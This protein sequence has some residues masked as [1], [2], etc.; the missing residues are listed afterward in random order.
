VPAVEFRNVDV[1]FGKDPTAALAMLDAGEDRAAILAQT[2]QVIGVA[3]ASIAIEE[4]EICV[5]MGLSGSGKSTLLRCVNGLNTVSRGQVLVRDGDTSID[6]A[7]CDADTLRRLRSTR[8]AMVF[9]QFALLPWRTVAE[10]VGLGLELRGTPKA[11]R[12][13]IVG[14]KLK[15]VS[16]DQWADKFAHELSG[17]MQ[18]RVG[19]ARAFATDA[20]ILLMD[21]PFSALDPLIR[22]HLQDELLELQRSLKKTIIF[23]SHDLDEALKIG[24]HIAIMDGGRIVQYGEPEQ[25]VLN[26]A[27]E[28]VAEFVAHM[29]PLNVLRGGSLMTPVAELRRD[30]DAVL[31]DRAGRLRLTLDGEDR[32]VAVTVNGQAGTV[33][34]YVP[35]AGGDLQARLAD[36]RIT[37]IAAPTDMSMRAAIE[38]RQA[39]GHPVVLVE[40]GKLVGV[41]GDEEI[42]RGILRQTDIA[43]APVLHAKAPAA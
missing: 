27:N 20:D 38:L 22:D 42:Y 9:Q 2:N 33:L 34:N 17:G 21:E 15:L 14:E 24:T 40:A 43:A 35:A 5:L 28:Y 41:C 37:V 25:I 11:E 8:I 36:G 23:V 29:N 30:G 16:L 26:P 4:G 19:L 39:S 6:V 13:R 32:P 1:V 18:Q 7:R 10:N 3:D 31:L 12:E